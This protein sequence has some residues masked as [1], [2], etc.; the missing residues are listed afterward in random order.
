MFRHPFKMWK[1]HHTDHLIISSAGKRWISAASSIPTQ[2]AALPHAATTPHSPTERL[3]IFTADNWLGCNTRKH[4]PPAKINVNWSCCFFLVLQQPNIMIKRG[5]LTLSCVH[6]VKLS[7]VLS[8]SLLMNRRLTSVVGDGFNVWNGSVHP[9]CPVLTSK[10]RPQ[11]GLY[12]GISSL[13]LVF[14]FDTWMVTS[15]YITTFAGSI[16]PWPCKAMS[17]SSIKCGSLCIYNTIQLYTHINIIYIPY[18]VLCIFI[19]MYIWWHTFQLWLRV[20]TQFPPV[21]TWHCGP[22]P[23]RTA[24]ARLCGPV[25]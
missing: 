25:P 4:L 1:I 3:A 23:S 5:K 14:G 21:R 15:H 7:V 24:A 2:A 9:P 13:N 10:R 11:N 8:Q 19:Y 22:L 18:Y 16:M 6:L 12:L 20:G 17:T